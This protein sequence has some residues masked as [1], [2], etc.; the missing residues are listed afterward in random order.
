MQASSSIR[1]RSQSTTTNFVII[2]PRA[3]TYPIGHPLFGQP[4]TT[5]ET[6]INSDSRGDMPPTNNLDIIN[7][8][9]TSRY[10]RGVVVV[11][12]GVEQYGLPPGQVRNYGTTTTDWEKA[13]ID[14]I[15]AQIKRETGQTDEEEEMETVSSGAPPLPK[16]IVRALRKS[17]R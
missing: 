8:F 5:P 12:P 17:V 10:E 2:S 15:I 11:W 4:F 16:E 14:K 13:E 6:S 9:L 7:T 1:F 3:G